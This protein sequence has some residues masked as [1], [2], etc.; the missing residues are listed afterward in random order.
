ME[1]LRHAMAGREH[2][3]NL[4]NLGSEEGVE[5][6]LGGNEALGD[7]NVANAG[8]GGDLLFDHFDFVMSVESVQVLNVLD[9]VGNNASGFVDVLGA[10]LLVMLAE[11]LLV[12]VEHLIRNKFEII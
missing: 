8:T 7:L 5:L 3:D 12:E 2:G 9:V 6:F 11:V 4:V 1:A 10:V